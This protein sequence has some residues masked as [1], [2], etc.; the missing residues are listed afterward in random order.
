M[1]STPQNPRKK[2][3]AAS[4]NIKAMDFHSKKLI[5]HEYVRETC[6]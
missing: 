5:Y 1:Y 6:C 3:T 4:T 2:L